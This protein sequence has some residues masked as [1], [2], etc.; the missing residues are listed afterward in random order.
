MK[1]EELIDEKHPDAVLLQYLAYPQDKI[2]KIL[3]NPTLLKTPIVRNGK[4]ATV[5]NQPEGW[6][7]WE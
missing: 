1:L 6:K 3:D 4:V 2:E 7:S 5:G